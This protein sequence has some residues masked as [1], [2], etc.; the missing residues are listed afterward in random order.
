MAVEACALPEN[1]HSIT[2]L[3]H[4]SMLGPGYL[5]GENWVLEPG[6][7]ERVMTPSKVLFLCIVGLLLIAG[8][9]AISKMMHYPS[10]PQSAADR[11]R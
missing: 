10:I 9:A 1:P 4:P 2:L 11:A 6:E 7:L 3:V 5:S 8:L